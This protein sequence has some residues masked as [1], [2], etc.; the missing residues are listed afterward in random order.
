MDQI[1]SAA[2]IE[3]PMMRTDT[4]AGIGNDFTAALEK[5]RQNSDKVGSAVEQIST[6]NAKGP[7]AQSLKDLAQLYTYAVNTQVI[8]RAANQVTSTAKQLMSGQ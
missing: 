1:V 8:V 7:A 3:T 5:F 2:L 6:G 4:G